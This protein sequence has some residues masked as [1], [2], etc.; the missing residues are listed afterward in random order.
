MVI[1]RLWGSGGE[2]KS[3]WSIYV[4]LHM[5]YKGGDNKLQQFA[6]KQILKNHLS[7]DCGLKLA[8]M[9]LESLVIVNQHVT[10]NDLS[11]FAHTAHHARRVASAGHLSGSYRSDPLKWLITALYISSVIVPGLISLVL[12]LISLSLVRYFVQ[13][14]RIPL[15]ILFTVLSTLIWPWVLFLRSFTYGFTSVALCMAVL[16]VRESHRINL[17]L[18]RSLTL[19]WTR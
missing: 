12:V 11:N 19:T 13:A 17:T 15:I 1:N 3:L 14:A 2:V 7:P 18:G 9:K 10:V 16:E 5:R 8:R 4:G 6:L